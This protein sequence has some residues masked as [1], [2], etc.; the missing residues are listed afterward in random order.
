MRVLH[1]VNVGFE[2]GGAEKSVRIIAE[3]LR[4]RGHEIHVLS[5]DH[6]IDG[7]QDCFADTVVPAVTGGAAARLA[8]YFW[9]RQAYRA[10]RRLIARFRPDCIHLHTIGE[11]SPS[12]L[13]AT[14]GLPRVLTVHGPEDWTLKLLRW[15]LAS[16]TRGGA[17]SPADRARYLYL[18]FMQRPAYLLWLRHI[19]RI[20]TPS[21]YFAGAVRRDVGKVPITVL[22]NGIEDLTGGEN[23]T[24]P[25]P[26]P[27]HV[28]YVGRLTRVKGVH[29]LLDAVRR[30]Q[31]QG[32]KARLSVVGD[33]DER[34]VLE[35]AAA[36]L[37]AT[38]A[39]TFHGW[40]SQDSVTRLV[41]SAAAVAIPS[42][43][44]ENFPTVA[45]EALQLGRPL[46]ASRVGGLP[47]LVGE[48]NGMLVPPGDPARLAA[49]LASV[50]G[51]ERRQAALSQGSNARARGYRVDA[52]LDN[53]LACYRE[54]SDR[55]TGQRSTS[56]E[57]GM[58]P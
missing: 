14:R 53:L 33:G 43:W 38:G 52:F 58:R 44:P 37:L 20:I 1:I 57:A 10:T 55:R 49:A 41:S 22:A 19:D 25:D 42:L 34:A 54:I 18:R 51:D 12:V 3:G 16:A 29:V 40:Q 11:F 30:L 47:E 24:L 32:I 15:N 56:S 46:I 39:A 4:A 27:Y 6:L 28:V 23:A 31:E 26:D 45:L 9:N 17:L 48:D 21:E 36:E 7:S 50:L 35:S 5:T 8:G 2:A 13:A